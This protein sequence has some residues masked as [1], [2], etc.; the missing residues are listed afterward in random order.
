MAYLKNWGEV[1]QVLDDAGA[2]RFVVSRSRGDSQGNNNAFMYD[3]E[4]SPEEN[5]QL[6]ERLLQRCAGEI[7][8]MTVWRSDSAKTG[9]CTYTICYDSTGM[10][11]QPSAAASVPQQM[12]GVGLYGTGGALDIETLKSDIR[13]QLKNEFERER[14]DRERKE[15]DD[16][17]KEFDAAR[18][19]SL[20]LLAQYLAPVAQQ[21]SGKLMPPLSRVAGVDA[22]APVHAQTRHAVPAPGADAPSEEAEE[23]Q[24]AFTEAEADTLYEL[25]ARFKAVEPDYMKLLTA[26]VEMAE[27]GDATYTM[28][29]GFLLK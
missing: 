22:N 25:L 26:V 1:V 28:A 23:E 29:K 21:L 9:G 24:S 8:Y 10:P 5:R 20:G 7:L 13:Q 16:A 4:K 2:K 27:N 14:L 17:R 19:S 12:S 18:N 6:A 3:N 11:A 15:L